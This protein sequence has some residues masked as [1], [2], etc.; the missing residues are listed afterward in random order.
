VSDVNA[1][2]FGVAFSAQDSYGDNIVGVDYI[3]IKVYYT[4][5]S[6]TD[7][8]SERGLYM[9]GYSTSTSERGLYLQGSLTS[10]ST[11]GLYI[12]GFVDTLYSRESS[13]SLR[14]DDSNLSTM[15]SEQDYTDVAT[16]DDTFVNLEGIAQYFQLL[17]KEP[18]GN[19]NNTDDFKITWK[20]KSSLAPSS[21][22][23]YLQI[24]NRT[25]ESWTTLVSNSSAN[26]NT[27][28]TLEDTVST[29]LSD[30]YDTNYIISVRV[31]QDG[32]V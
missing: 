17:F 22:A 23:V 18:N 6:G 9:T 28:F 19:E 31:Y 14:A 26:A 7:A 21:S 32:V 1:S 5:S 25:A 8:D 2:N 29:N 30:Y 24:Y 16:D 3:I 4:E 15:F 10:N 13:A 20:G 11:R 27:E 12:E